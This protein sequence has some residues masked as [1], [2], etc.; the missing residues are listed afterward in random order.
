MMADIVAMCASFGLTVSEAKT[1]TMCQM[2]KRMDRVTFFAE[3]AGQVYKQTAKFV[4][5][6]ATVCE[7]ADLTVEINRRVL[8]ANLRFGRYGPPLYD[9]R[10][11]PLRL[12]V[13]T[14]K[15]EVMDAMLYRCVTWSPTVAHLAILRKTHYRLLLRC[16]GWK[17]KHGDGYHVLS[18]ADAVAKTD[19]L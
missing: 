10:T 16:I 11:A 15:A 17:R 2:A 8:L 9:Q 13:R 5:L 7:N 12:K 1:E 19:W 3:A 14:L 6:G 18:F 4:Y